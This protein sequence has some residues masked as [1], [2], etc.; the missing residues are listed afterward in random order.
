MTRYYDPDEPIR[1]AEQHLERETY[2]LLS[3]RNNTLG[4]Q[5]E[6]ERRA[7]SFEKEGRYG[8]AAEN[9]AAVA[10]YREEV[11]QLD[12]KLAARNFDQDA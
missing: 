4:F 9:W 7:K 6:A 5:K 3:E 8:D 2:G 1:T 11:R 12:A 10:E